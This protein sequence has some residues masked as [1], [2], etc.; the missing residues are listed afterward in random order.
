MTFFVSMLAVLSFL[1][2]AILFFPCWRV[3]FKQSKRPLWIVTII[4]ISSVG[5][6]YWHWGSA[7]ALM[8]TKILEKVS[9]ALVTGD[10]EKAEKEARD[11]HVAL[12]RLGA[13]YLELGRLNKSS[14]LFERAIQLAPGEND[15][16]VQWIYSHALQ[17]GGRLPDRVRVAAL[18]KVGQ[19]SVQKEIINLLAVDAYLRGQYEDAIERWQTL[20][21]TDKHLSS[22]KRLVLQKA[23]EKARQRG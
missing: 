10:F 5:G 9:S 18:E 11:S 6:L 1:A 4:F 16:W 20:L 21:E 17:N 22:E 8:H 19:A 3:C 14:A 23:I 15:Y 13:L 12:G 2:L 7:L